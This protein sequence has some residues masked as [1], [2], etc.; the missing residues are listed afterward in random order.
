MSENT[1][2][3]KTNQIINI[4]L[5]AENTETNFKSV[6]ENIKIVQADCLLALEKIESNSVDCIITDPPYFLDGMENN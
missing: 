1:T 4:S 6:K 2:T 5:F 3:Q